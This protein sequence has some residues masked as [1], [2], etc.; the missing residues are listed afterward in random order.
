MSLIMLL[1]FKIALQNSILKLTNK[2]DYFCAI[3][4]GSN[5]NK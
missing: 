4:I 3:K 5:R 2:I 1:F